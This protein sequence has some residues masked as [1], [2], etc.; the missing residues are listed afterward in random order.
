MKGTFNILLSFFFLTAI[1]GS[2]ARKNKLENVDGFKPIYGNAVDLLKINCLAKRNYL[3]PGKILQKGNLTFQID[4]TNGVHV[5][6]CTNLSQ[7]EKLHFIT[8]PG[9][10]DIHLKDNI[11]FANNLSDMVAIDISNLP[12]INETM[13]IKNQF[14]LTNTKVPPGANVFFECIDYTK[15]EVIGWEKAILENPTCKTF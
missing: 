7:P 14:K 12:N 8:I 10:S 4:E 11:L 15:G 5:I 2:C 3:N 6:D 1:G 9:V 13:R